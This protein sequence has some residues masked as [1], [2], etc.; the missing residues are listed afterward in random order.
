[1]CKMDGLSFDFDNGILHLED[2]QCPIRQECA[3]NGI[4]CHPKPLNLNNKEI[5]MLT[6]W[7]QGETY[8]EISDKMNIGQSSIKNSIHNI[9][10]RMKL[11]CAKDLMKI[12]A[13]IL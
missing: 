7:K 10:K 1:M 13:A 12:A 2:I 11:G 4:V 6:L 9:T 3:F 5:K 8:K